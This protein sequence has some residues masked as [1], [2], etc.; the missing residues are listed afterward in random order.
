MARTV[1]AQCRAGNHRTPALPITPITHHRT[2]FMAAFRS[3]GGK[4]T[5]GH[6]AAK[7]CCCCQADYDAR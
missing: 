1:D 4:G 5:R 7:G 2:N 6:L 3:D